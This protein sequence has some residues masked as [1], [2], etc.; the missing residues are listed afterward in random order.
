VLTA[1]TQGSERAERQNC[2][3]SHEGARA[4]SFTIT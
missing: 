4:Y 2:G 3:G 1:A